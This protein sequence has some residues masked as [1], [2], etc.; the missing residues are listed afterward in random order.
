MSHFQLKRCN[1]LKWNF[2]L[3]I[4]TICALYDASTLSHKRDYNADP[5]AIDC[6]VLLQICQKYLEIVYNTDRALIQNLE[7]ILQEMS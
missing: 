5:T 4:A 1:L 3:A 6:K 2:V 7:R